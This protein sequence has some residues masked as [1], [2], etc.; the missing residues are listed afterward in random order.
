MADAESSVHC[1]YERRSRRFFPALRPSPPRIT[2]QPAIGARYGTLPRM[3]VA[4]PQEVSDAVPAARRRQAVNARQEIRKTKE[5]SC[6]FGP[7][8][9]ADGVILHYF[10]SSFT[11]ERQ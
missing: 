6:R 4:T 8:I 3:G 5:K 11:N 10:W 1:H 7:F 2:V 9:T